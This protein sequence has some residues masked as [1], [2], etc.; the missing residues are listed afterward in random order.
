MAGAEGSVSVSVLHLD[1]LPRSLSPSSH[2]WGV[3]HPQPT[4]EATALRSGKN[5]VWGFYCLPIC[6]KRSQF[7]ASLVVT[8]LILCQVAPSALIADHPE[9]K[10]PVVI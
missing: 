3:P 7:S 4:R 9:A 8:S 5:C 10:G 2:P 6:V 1:S